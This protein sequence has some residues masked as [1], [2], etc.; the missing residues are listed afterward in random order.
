MEISALDH[1]VIN[2][3]D[4]ET[5]AA[6]YVEVME[7][8][9][10]EYGTDRDHPR[11]ALLFGSQRI[12]RRP[13]GITKQEWF[14]A[15]HETAGSDD[16]CFLTKSSPVE[17]VAHLR[18]FGVDI[19]SGPDDRAGARGKLRSVYCRDPDGNLIEISSSTKQ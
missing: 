6:W 19:V 7:M 4:V 15:D 9:R 10:L 5:S 14:T 12:N 11:T 13:V 1:L 2:L 17:V 18:Q 3:T 8:K 16:L